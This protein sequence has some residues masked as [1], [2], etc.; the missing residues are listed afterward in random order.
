Q[1]LKDKELI[2][3][4]KDMR[5]QFEDSLRIVYLRERP[6]GDPILSTIVSLGIMDIFNTNSFDLSVFVEQLKAKPQFSKVAKFLSSNIFSDTSKVNE[7]DHQTNEEEINENESEADENLNPEKQKQVVQKVIEKKVVQ[8][9][10]NKTT[11]KRDYTFHV[12]NH[13]EK[14]VGIPV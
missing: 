4:L 13:T 5:I 2:S 10:V 1:E 9:V 3:F 14:I 12:H 7:V 6:K 8:K 11:I